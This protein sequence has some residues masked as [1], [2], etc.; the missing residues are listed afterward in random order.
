MK[1][2]LFLVVAAVIMAACGNDGESAGRG[3][4][5]GLKDVTFQVNGDFAVRFSDMATRTALTDEA[6]T[7]TD[8]WVF[9]YKDGQCVQSIHQTSGDAQWGTPTL[10]LRFGTHQIYF[11]ASRGAEPVVD[12]DNHVI[13]FGTVRDTFW[14]MYTIEVTSS[15]NAS[16][17]VAMDRVV[18]RLRL[19]ATDEVPEGLATVTITPAKWYNGVDF[20]TGEPAAEV[21]ST[22]R[23]VNVPSSYAGT[24]GDL[25]INVFG[26]SADDFSTN[27]DV[28]AKTTDGTT[29]GQ[30]SVA[31]APFKRNRSTEMSGTLFGKVSVN[32]ITIDDEWLDDYEM[33]F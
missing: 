32:T 11:V 12:A 22:G 21:V 23:M 8:L 17:T 31:N 14:K 28:V 27:I 3:D 20:L 16:R 7:M 5:E 4:S 2:N 15:T 29:I 18:T 6:N 19:T 25:I 26:F 10:S 33:T 1:K 9:D 24:S 13:S 30:A